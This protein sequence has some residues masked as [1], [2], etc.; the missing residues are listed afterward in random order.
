MRRGSRDQPRGRR[1]P[2]PRVRPTN[3]SPESVGMKQRHTPSLQVKACRRFTTGCRREQIRMKVLISVA[4]GG[5]ARQGYWKVPIVRDG[6]A[7]RW[8]EA[9]KMLVDATGQPGPATWEAGSYAEGTAD[10]PVTGISW[11]EAAAY[12][13]FAGKSLPTVY[14]WVQ[15][16]ANP[17][18][19]AY[20][21]P[22]S[23][24]ASAGLWPVGR[25]GA[26]GPFGAFD[27]GGNA[28]E[29]CW[30]ESDGKRFIL[31]GSYADPNY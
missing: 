21:V 31:G 12:A 14:H 22:L 26:I 9:M 29:W 5:Y 25:S 4:N 7:T 20:Q 23:N 6:R 3:R 27:M 8:E 30:N 28:R 17:N 11:Y 1:V 2:M 16:G 24:F 10:Q 18:E 19:S 13:E 15:A